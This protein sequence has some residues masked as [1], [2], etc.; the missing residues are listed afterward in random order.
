MPE[1]HA[2]QVDDEVAPSSSENVPAGQM[3][4]DPAPDAALYVPA[5]HAVHVPPLGPVKPALHAQS[6]EVSLPAGEVDPAM[7]HSRQLFVH[8]A[9]YFGYAIS[10]ASY[11]IARWSPDQTVCIYQRWASRLALSAGC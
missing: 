8:A 4:H 1:G 6:E 3:L 10:Y 2:E 5:A 9:S 7:M 11:G